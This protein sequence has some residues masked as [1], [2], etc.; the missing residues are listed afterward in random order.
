MSN[1]KL[2]IIS[3]LKE[4][5]ALPVN[6]AV[7]LINLGQVKF[8]VFM[9]MYAAGQIVY[10]EP[11]TEAN[12]NLFGFRALVFNPTLA[13]SLSKQGQTAPVTAYLPKDVPANLDCFMFPDLTKE[14]LKSDEPITD[15]EPVKASS[16]D[17]LT[18]IVDNG[19]HRTLAAFNGLSK[20]TQNKFNFKVEIK[21]PKKPV[22]LL[23]LTDFVNQ[24]N[25]QRETNLGELF[26]KV[27]G[28]KAAYKN[29]SYAQLL[30]LAGCNKTG[31]GLKNYA[32]RIGMMASLLPYDNDNNFLAYLIEKNLL[33][34]NN[35]GNIWSSKNPTLCREKYGLNNKK[36]RE[37]D[38][39]FYPNVAKFLFDYCTAFEVTTDEKTHSNFSLG[40]KALLE[41]WDK[42]KPIEA[43]ENNGKTTYKLSEF[44]PNK[45]KLES[46]FEVAGFKSPTE[47]ADEIINVTKYIK[48]L[49]VTDENTKLIDNCI[50]KEK[51]TFDINSDEFK[52][53]SKLA[54][55]HF[56][57][58]Q[59]NKEK[60]FVS[61]FFD[62]VTEGK[63][64][65]K[66][67]IGYELSQFF[68]DSMERVK[69][70]QLEL[71]KAYF[72]K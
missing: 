19:K 2:V 4:L 35:L 45:A 69:P 43:T 44:K 11:S 5:N 49:E 57:R 36:Q 15:S 52:T 13:T 21:Q 17:D 46:A 37:T 3:S 41:F 71:L 63:G 25:L 64:D 9:E 32:S 67:I 7:E 10:F 31:Q 16:L 48:Q 54:K 55:S 38:N 68:T 18:I 12:K 58:L 51:N 62:E 70:E 29:K 14:Q 72:T 61:R 8:S 56:D 1:S 34:F 22:S 23:D 65:D 59:S 28:L 47:K 30:P 39:T 6:E 40:K 60:S 42:I 20:T 24:S 27:T 33:T 66:K 50:V 53:L 26:A